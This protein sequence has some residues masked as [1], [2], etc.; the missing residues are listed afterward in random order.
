MA[1]PMSAGGA[2]TAQKS[3][4]K[5]IFHQWL[6][7]PLPWKLNCTVFSLPRHLLLSC[8]SFFEAPKLCHVST[9]KIRAKNETVLIKQRLCNNV[10][11][12]QALSKRETHKGSFYE[13]PLVRDKPVLAVVVHC[14]L[15]IN[16]IFKK[17]SHLNQG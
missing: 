5:D 3:K 13:K 4:M 6:L 1:A 14:K 8:A 7:Q 2:H 10:P 11:I 17:E 12:L 9:D 16:T 15:L